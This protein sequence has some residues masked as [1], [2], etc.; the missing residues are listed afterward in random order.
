M[1]KFAV[2]SAIIGNY[3]S[4]KQPLCISEDFDYYL[5]TNS[6]EIDRVG[7]WQVVQ[8][9]YKISDIIKIAR[10]IKTHSH[11]LLSNY[12]ATL[13]MDANLQIIDDYFYS[14]VEKL[15]QSNVEFASVQH[16][17]RSCAYVEAFTMTK[18]RFEQ[19]SVAIKWCNKLLKESYPGNNGLYETNIVYRRN[20]PIV[21]TFNES[22][23]QCISSFSRRDQ[24]SCNYVLWKHRVQNGF[25]L[26]PG[27]HSMNS[28]HVG[29]EYHNSVSKRKIVSVS[30]SAYYRIR[31]MEIF[32][33]YSYKSFI[34]LSKFGYSKFM[35]FI[36]G[37][38]S[39][40]IFS[41]YIVCRKVAF[42]FKKK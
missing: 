16:P 18:W 10:Y 34:T 24:F 9:D 38:L 22:W 3:D 2:Y 5:F 14:E 1:K 27:E 21:S 7:V 20:C 6:S 13:W 15:Y 40:I 12:A 30:F 19:D 35:I 33:E 26:P 23:W 37:W 32:P 39:I 4:V 8:V 31:L 28:E 41:P 42:L 36:W 17:E 25:I 29:Y 11:T